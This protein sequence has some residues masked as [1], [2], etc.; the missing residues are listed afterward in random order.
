MRQEPPEE[1]SLLL[2]F[3]TPDELAALTPEEIR[4]LAALAHEEIPEVP[5]QERLQAARD[6]HERVLKKLAEQTSPPAASHA[7]DPG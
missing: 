7:P 3:F 5:E 1:E 4:F 2:L 6:Y